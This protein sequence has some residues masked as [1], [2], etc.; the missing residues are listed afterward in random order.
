MNIALWVIAA[1][2]ALAVASA[3]ATKLVSSREDLLPRMPWVAD[4]RQLRSVASAPSHC[5]ARSA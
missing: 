4:S 5:S 3:G 2:L 1:N